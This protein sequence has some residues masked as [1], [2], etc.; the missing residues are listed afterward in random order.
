MEKVV[1]L[2]ENGAESKAVDDGGQTA[3]DHAVSF[4]FVYVADVLRKAMEFNRIT[5]LE[6]AHGIE[7]KMN[8]KPQS[9]SVESPITRRA[10]LGQA[11]PAASARLRWPVCSTRGRTRSRAARGR[12]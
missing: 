3:L 9:A 12:R 10:M 7:E 5:V 1:W 8:D 4:G 6:I 11:G 2:L